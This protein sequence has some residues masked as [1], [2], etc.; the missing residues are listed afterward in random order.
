MLTYG[1]NVYKNGGASSIP[2]YNEDEENTAEDLFVPVT[3]A[4]PESGDELAG[5]L[6]WSVRNNLPIP[7][8]ELI[9]LPE[10]EGE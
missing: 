1:K 9:E 6:I 4:L 3:G 2:E 5:L 8:P 10:G 7:E